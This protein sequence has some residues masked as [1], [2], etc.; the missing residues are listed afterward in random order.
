MWSRSVDREIRGT[1]GSLS[2]MT[3]MGRKILGAGPE[4][5]TE[6]TSDQMVEWLR[7]ALGVSLQR[8]GTCWTRQGQKSPAT[9]GPGGAG[10]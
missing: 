5:G 10:L 6:A 9:A 7:V 2:R 1:G 3:L 8:W 4:E